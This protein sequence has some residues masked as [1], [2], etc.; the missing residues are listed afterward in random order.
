MT[1]KIAPSILSCNFA[2]MGEELKWLDQSECE[3]I[4]VDVMDGHFVPNLTFGPPVIRAI[5]PC[6]KKIFD[7]HLMISEPEK[8]LEAYASAG[9]DIIGIHVEVKYDKIEL[10]KKIRS[11]GKRASLTFNPDTS[12]EGVEKYFPYVDQILLMSVFPGFGG[13]K[14]IEESLVRGK[15]VSDKIGKSGW[16]IDLEIDGGVSEANAAKIKQAG[17]NILVAGNA[18]FHASSPMDMI[19]TLRTI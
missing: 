16:S 3:Y 11:L 12:L 4:H 9:A 14:F 10:L 1:V 19:H 6:T 17:F 18:V 15:S 5:R 8:Y 7:V 13:Q 2:K